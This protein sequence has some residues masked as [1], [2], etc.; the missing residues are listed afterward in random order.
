MKSFDRIVAVFLALMAV[1]IIAVNII[2]LKQNKSNI[3]MYKVEVN[4]IKQELL[5]GRQA[6]ADNYPNIIGIL[7]VLSPIVGFD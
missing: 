4:R 5:M 7:S 3:P 1:S 2:L 6:S